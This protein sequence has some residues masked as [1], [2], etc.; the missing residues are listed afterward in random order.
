MATIEVLLPFIE[1]P[2]ARGRSP[3]AS[4]PNRLFGLSGFA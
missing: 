2:K 4:D 3:P 1:R